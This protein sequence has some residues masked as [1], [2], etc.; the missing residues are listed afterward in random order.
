MA[1]CLVLGLG[2]GHKKSD[3]LV[4]FPKPADQFR[5]GVNKPPGLS[6]KNI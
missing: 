6:N 5:S 1:E 2:E 3:L 4:E